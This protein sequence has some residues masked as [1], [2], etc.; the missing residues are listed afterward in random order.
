MA[1]ETVTRL[2]AVLIQCRDFGI[3]HSLI[4]PLG[5]TPKIERVKWLLDYYEKQG[6]RIANIAQMRELI[7]QIK[8]LGCEGM[9]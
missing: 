8:L 9:K 4:V 5:F 3:A 7:D 2:A 1:D 6:L